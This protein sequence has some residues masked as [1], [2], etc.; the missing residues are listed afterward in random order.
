MQVDGDGRSMDVGGT[1]E[2][3]LRL[4]EILLLERLLHR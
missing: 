3:N 2:E 1:G 4:L